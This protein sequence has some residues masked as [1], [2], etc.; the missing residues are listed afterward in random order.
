MKTTAA[1]ENHQ[2]I[3]RSLTCMSKGTF[4]QAILD[5]IF[6]A[7][8][9]QLQNRKCKPGAIF[10]AI[11][12]RDIPGVS[13]MFETRCNFTATNFR[14]DKNRMC[15]RAFKEIYMLPSAHNFAEVYKNVHKCSKDHELL[16]NKANTKRGTYYLYTFLQLSA[17]Q[18]NF[19]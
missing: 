12:R 4:T 1:N 11:C 14:R 7:L 10:S 2:T 15:E 3:N 16:K 13:N 17:L 6:V 19:T 8:N 9:L 5:A 18:T